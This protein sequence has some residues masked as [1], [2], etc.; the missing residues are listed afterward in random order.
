MRAPISAAAGDMNL[1]HALPLVF[2]LLVGMML[3]TGLL[4]QR[5]YEPP[6]S[7]LVGTPMP[8]LDLPMLGSNARF[9]PAVWKNK[10]VMLNMFSSWCMPCLREHPSLTKL[11]KTGKIDIIGIAWKDNADNVKAWLDEHGN[12]YRAVGIDEHRATTIP[13]GLTGV[14]ET[15][16]I[17]RD[18]TIVLNHKSYLTDEI[19]ESTI[20][21]FIE[22]LEKKHAPAP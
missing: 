14:P 18:G 13:L 3:G 5:P 4:M 8:A 6:Q 10:I 2:W 19:I 16:I 9:S 15:F 17:D 7:K 20:I 11:A 21:P 22:N 1:R 12:P